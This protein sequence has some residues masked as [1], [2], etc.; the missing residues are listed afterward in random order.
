MQ[1]MVL[2]SFYPS[3]HINKYGLYAQCSST[4]LRR[5][6]CVIRGVW[7]SFN[8]A[9]AT[10]HPN[11]SLSS[12]LLLYGLQGQCK[13]WVL[14][15][16]FVVCTAALGVQEQKERVW[17]RRMKGFGPQLFYA[18]PPEKDAKIFELKFPVEPHRNNKSQRFCRPSR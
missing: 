9:P 11:C 14:F 8:H 1:G 4:S 6:S 18:V 2:I 13:R 15:A 12:L 7:V 17:G 16:A 10:T 5:S 3:K